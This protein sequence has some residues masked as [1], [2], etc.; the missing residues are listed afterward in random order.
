MKQ[1]NKSINQRLERRYKEKN[2]VNRLWQEKKATKQVR[3]GKQINELEKIAM[4][5]I[6][7]EKV[8]K[9]VNKTNK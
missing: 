5:A 7:K 1:R 9:Q 4:N 2:K 6:R 3:N 8:N